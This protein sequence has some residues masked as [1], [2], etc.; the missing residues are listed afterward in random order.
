MP[1]YVIHHEGRYNL[2]STI[3][4]QPI[5]PESL[6]LEQLE[7]Y[8][9][10]RSGK[11]GLRQLEKKL[12]RAHQKG[13]SELRMTLQDCVDDYNLEINQDVSLEQFIERFLSK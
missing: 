13:C 3:V 2:F 10:D 7:A 12:E 11:E 8:I 9:Q 6:S 1:R 5:F 4:N